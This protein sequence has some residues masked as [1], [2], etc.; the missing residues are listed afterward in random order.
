M[1]MYFGAAD[2]ASYTV[3]V[4]TVDTLIN[5]FNKSNVTINNIAFEGA[6]LAAIYFVDGTNR[7]ITNCSINNS[8]AKGIFGRR[9]KIPF[10]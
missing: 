10:A 1:S 5:L 4:S 2:P 7:T 3:K 8:G 6:N 9:I